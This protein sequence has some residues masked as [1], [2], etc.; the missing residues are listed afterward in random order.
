MKRSSEPFWWSLFGAGGMISAIFIPAILIVQGVA[1][2]LGWIESPNYHSMHQL[3]GSLA[4][5]VFLLA[6]ICLSLLHWAHRFRFT[7]YD[8]LQVKHLNALIAIFCYG[9]AI[10]GSLTAGYYLWII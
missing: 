6:L 1:I 10:L 4:T 3:F 8:G 9:S 7:L 2:P 5:K